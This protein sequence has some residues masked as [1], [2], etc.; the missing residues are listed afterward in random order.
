M[1]EDIVLVG[2]GGHAKSVADCVERQGKYRIIG[3]TDLHPSESHYAYLGK[4]DVLVECYNKGIRNAAICV[5]YLGAGNIRQKIYSNIKEI[6][7]NLPIIIDPSA[8]V[9]SSAKIEEGV[10]IGKS[11]VINSEA[12]IGKCVIINSKALIEHECEV[13][14]FSH[15]AVAAVLCGQVKVGSAAFVGAN[16]TVIQCREVKERQ[17]VPAGAVIR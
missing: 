4:D 6:G 12:K 7:F 13:G 1:T 5:G 10:F 15:I 2:F 9:S 3:Y 14:E 17:I 11:A 8:V 16:S